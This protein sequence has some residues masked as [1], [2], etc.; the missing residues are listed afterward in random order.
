M[1]KYILNWE[2][3]LKILKYLPAPQEV[4]LRK[5]SIRRIANNVFHVMDGMAETEQKYST[6]EIEQ[7]IQKGR[8]KLAQNEYRQAYD[9]FKEIIQKKSNAR[10][11]IHGLG[12]ACQFMS[13]YDEALQSYQQAYDISLQLPETRDIQKEKGLHLAGIAN[14]L[15]GLGKIEEANSLWERVIDLDRSLVWMK[16]NAQSGTKPD[17][18][19]KKKKTIK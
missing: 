11:A 3:I 7:D 19:K 8:K 4:V 12:D 17:L 10:W 2:N 1:G 9:I 5:L 14:A 18:E 15:A 16:E 6:K 13:C